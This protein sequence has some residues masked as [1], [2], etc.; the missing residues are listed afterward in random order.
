MAVDSNTNMAADLV[1]ISI[2]F[3]ERFNDNIKKLQEALGIARL[4]SMSQGNQIKIYKSEVTKANKSVGEGE[5][6]PLS[7]V[8]KKLAKTVTL[9]YGKYRKLTTAESIQANGFEEA[10]TETDNKLLREIQKGLKTD[11]FGFMTG[12]TGTTT[13]TADTFKAG[14]AKTLGQMA[15]QWEDYDVE[16]VLFINPIDFYDYLAKA[17]LTTQTA[18]GL[19]YIKDFMGFSKVVMNT[20]IPQG[21]IYAT[22][23]E[24]INLAYANVNGGALNR[25]FNFTTDETGLIGVT[26]NAVNENLTY[27]TVI[28]NGMVMFPERTDGIIETTISEGNNSNTPS[29]SNQGE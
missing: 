10:V 29:G 21:K 14:I 15:V 2:D 18:F 17:E 13:A 26:H 11:F 27:Q 19:N 20:A 25:A 9:D 12:L 28:V 5:T 3:R 23:S 1:N 22:P 6:I 16:P 24:N 7:K 8:T 4:T